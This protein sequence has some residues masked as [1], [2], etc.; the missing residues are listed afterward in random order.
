M[1]MIG[2]EIIL[3][4]ILTMK[5]ILLIL[6]VIVLSMSGCTHK[7]DIRNTKWQ[8][9]DSL[10]M[11]EFR[12]STC[13]FVDISKYTGN[14]DSIW[15]KYTNVQDT[16]TLIPLQ[17]HITFNTRFLVTDSG[18]VNLKKHIVVAKEIK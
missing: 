13:L 17:E 12:D 11:I 6:I 2:T 18:L 3:N 10:N 9:I 16:I 14:K 8:S 4:N 15:A 7:S 5:M 1:K